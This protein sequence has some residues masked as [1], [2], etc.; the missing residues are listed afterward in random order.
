MKEETKS[1][2]YMI[3][4]GIVGCIAGLIP[5]LAIFIL[6]KGLVKFLLGVYAMLTLDTI[7]ILVTFSLIYVIHA[8]AKLTSEIFDFFIGLIDEFGA[9]YNSDREKRKALEE[10]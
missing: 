2:I 6:L 3:L 1:L 5:I 10:K 7:V 8:M 4:I 9:R